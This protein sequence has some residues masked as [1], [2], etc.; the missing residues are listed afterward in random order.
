MQDK[1]SSGAGGGQQDQVIGVHGGADPPHGQVAP[2][3]VVPELLSSMLQYQHQKIGLRTAP[4]R[5]LVE[6][7]N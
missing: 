6:M 4:W 3:V 5:V 2:D 1:R 7:V